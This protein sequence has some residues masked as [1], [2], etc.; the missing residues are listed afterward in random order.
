MQYE[1][2]RRRG[3]GIRSERLVRGEKQGAREGGRKEGRREYSS[4]QKNH[5]NAEEGN[6]DG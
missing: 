1:K 4:V 2:E 3:R 5:L 6:H